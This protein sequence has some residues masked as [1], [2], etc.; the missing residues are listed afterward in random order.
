[1]PFLI[2]WSLKYKNS[3]NHVSILHDALQL[4]GGDFL[5]LISCGEIISEKDIAKFKSAFVL[6]ASD[7][8]EGKGWSPHI[9]NILE[10]KSILT[11]SL[12]SVASKLDMGD[13]WFKTKINLEGHELFDEINKKIFEAELNLMSEVIDSINSI[14]PI[15]Q[16]E[17]NYKYYP[18]RTPEDSRLDPN[19]TFVEQFNLL[20][21]ADKDRYPTFFEYLGHKYIVTI[22]KG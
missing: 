18:K 17:N 10:G 1:M 7:L 21:V 2:S 19:K 15:K 13:I 8:P 14:R 16:L 4:N 20:R 9:W 12:L 6:H 3:N 22:Q 5:F 11:V